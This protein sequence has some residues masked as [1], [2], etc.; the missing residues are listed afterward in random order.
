MANILIVYS[1]TDGHTL[2]ICQVL[3]QTIE[4][5]SHDVKLASITE[6]PDGALGLF[7]K[8][9]VGASIRYGKH[10]PQVYEFIKRNQKLLESIPS[11]FFTVNVVAR[12]P[13]KN[14]PQTN[15]YLKKFLE[16]SAWQPKEL[17]VFAGKLDYQ[18][19]KFWDRQVIR[20]IMK[21]TQGPTDP[22]SVTEFTNWLEVEKF[23]QRISVM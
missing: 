13:L 16:K 19:Y 20:L 15:P 23:G 12:K 2:K 8:I 6:E 22:N 3:K 10:R 18:K 9:V 7:D 5:G 17:G 4:R 21:L 14:T 1:S 11:A